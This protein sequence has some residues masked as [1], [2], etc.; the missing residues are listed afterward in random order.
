MQL[1]QLQKAKQRFEDK[2]IG[3][4]AI[5]YDSE[6]ILK[7]FSE[8]QKID[9]PL[10]ADPESKI[11]RQFGVLNTEAAGMNKGMA[12]PGFMYL[13]KGGIVR[14]KFF[15]AAYTDRVTAQNL[16]GK[17]FPELIERAGKPIQGEHLVL[18]A[19]QSDR[20]VVPGSKITLVANIALPKD[21][22]VYAPGVTGYIPIELSVN[23]APE[24][25]LDATN[26][27]KSRILYLPVIKE[28]V[29][30]FEGTFRITKDVTITADRAFTRSLGEGKNLTVAGELKYQACDHAI[31]YMPAAL[32]ISW[33]VEVKPLDP[34][35]APESIRH[36]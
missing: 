36:H 15:E 8:R 19:G 32:P 23:Q 14:E 30:V 28:R 21:V 27:P 2:G 1:V 25:K 13:D 16:I 26:Y 33:Q 35:R 10:L 31:C 20:V 3:L 7:D 12:Y 24:I 5:S 6:A 11:I 18:T 29:P 17:L 34:Q 4:A 22:H 9:V